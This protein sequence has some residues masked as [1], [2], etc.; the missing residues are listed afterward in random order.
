MGY[1]MIREN[2][3]LLTRF[4]VAI[5]IF[6][7]IG[8]I[9]GQFGDQ[10]FSEEARGSVLI[11]AI[12]FVTIFV[13]I[14]LAFILLIVLSS[15]R[16]SGAVSRR[17]YQPIERIIIAGILIGVVAMFQ[18]WKTFIYEYGFLTL[19]V[20]TLLFMIWSHIT[21]ASARQKHREAALDRRAH[22]VGLA[23][24]IIVTVLVAYALS[25]AAKPEEPYGVG[26]SVWN[27]MSDE[28]KAITVA[29]AESEYTGLVIP[30]FILLSTL[31]GAI[32]YFGFREIA[33]VRQKLAEV[34]PAAMNP[35]SGQ[36]VA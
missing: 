25:S 23:A 11:S 7:A 15:I 3:S 2:R 34:P 32:S 24:A 28:D 17:A 13:A 19:L 29:E 6:I 30:L 35:Q 9:S 16:L 10:I 36:H 22:I 18:P 5:L 33:A 8:V 1:V 31:P 27:F 4:A 21:P 20:S 26:R 12:P 14:L